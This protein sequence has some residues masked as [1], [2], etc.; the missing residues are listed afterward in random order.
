MSETFTVVP[1]YFEQ[2]VYI[3][4]TAN[5]N[6]KETGSLI[7]YG[8]VG[9][10]KNLHVG[11]SVYIGGNL[12]VDGE[13]TYVNTT[14][15]DVADNS[16]LINAGPMGSRDAGVFIARH[17]TDVTSEMS[18]TNGTTTVLYNTGGVLEVP[19][20]TSGEYD[21][22]WVKVSSGNDLYYAQV[23]SSLLGGSPGTTTLLFSTNGNTIPTT[24]SLSGTIDLYKRS[25]FGLYLD[26]QTD[27]FVFG[28]V[29]DPSDPKE[30]FDSSG[31][32]G[33]IRLGNLDSDTMNIGVGISAGSLFVSGE[34]RLLDNVTTGA[35][36]VSGASF[37]VV[38]TN[39]SFATPPDGSILFNGIDISPSANDITRERVF[40]IPSD[41]ETNRSVTDFTFSNLTTRSFEASVSI[42]VEYDE[43]V[44]YSLYS[45]KGL[46]RGTVGNW[47]FNSNFIGDNLALD[48]SIS[49]D[50]DT[51]QIQ[52]TIGE[53]AGLV[54]TGSLMKFRALTTSV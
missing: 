4:D 37:D 23:Q 50:D 20:L 29:S 40:M 36:F 47:Y 34:S 45:L 28:Y 38:A 41:D 30:D 25:Y 42:T 19:T 48:F 35:L 3:L 10:D 33:D 39:I 51:A 49:S 11:D 12:F 18:V 22:W 43:G 53:Y 6:S 16:L 2:S 52:Y 13:T 21:G 46:Q 17:S 27:Q 24:G 14:T 31:M 8:G 15:L 9:I 32:L 54:S 5:S 44:K 26:E 7:V 1:L